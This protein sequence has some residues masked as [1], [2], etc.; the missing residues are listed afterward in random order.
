MKITVVCPRCELTDH[1]EEDQR[2]K[3]IRCPNQLCRAIIEVPVE[4]DK[5]AAAA[6][7]PAPVKPPAPAVSGMVSDMLPLLPAQFAEPTPPAP[8]PPL[9]KQ[10]PRPPKPAAKEAPA[11]K[12]VEPPAPVPAPPV[13]VTPAPRRPAPPIDFPDDFP[14]DD[15]ADGVPAPGEGPREMGPGTWEAPPVRG[16][17]AE[18]APSIAT[19]EPPPIVAPPPA[20]G[21]ATR[22]RTLLVIAAMAVVCAG[23][24]GFGLWRLENTRA[25]SEADRF[26]RALELYDQRE[27]EKT[28]EMLQK[29]ARDFPTSRDF[30]KYHFLAELSSVRADADNARELAEL[31]PAL[32]HVLQFLGYNQ[33]QTLL[34][35]RHADVWKT[36]HELSKRLTAEADKGHDSDA[37]R[38]AQQAWT[39]AKK[40]QPPAGINV[41][42]EERLFTE[43]F[44]GVTKGI[45][46]HTQR[47]GVIAAIKD[48]IAQATAVGVQQSRALA[49]AAGLKDDP[50]VTGLLADLVRAHRAAVK[51]EPATRSAVSEPIE[52]DDLP[53]LLVTPALVKATAGASPGRVVLAL[54]RGVLYALDPACGD[55]RWAR[56][57][58]IDTSVLPLHV[59]ADPITPELLLVVSSDS[60][61]IT[62]VVAATGAVAW[63]HS[64]AAPCKGQPVLVGRTLLVPTVTGRVDELEISGGRLLGHYELGQRLSVG[65]ARQPGSSLV[66]FPGDEFCVYALDVAK[67]TGAAVLYS[68]H[69]AGSLRGVPILLPAPETPAKDAEPG[70]GPPGW[71]LLCQAKGTAAVEVRPFELPIRDPDQAPLTLKTPVNVPGLSWFAPWH[72]AE[73]LALATDKGLLSLWG[74]RQK[75]N[76]DDP[77][78]FAL[79]HDFAVGSGP[80]RA[81]VVHAD[82]DDYW[83]LVGGRLHRLTAVFAPQSGPDLVRAWQK[84]PML[85]SPLHAAQ[86]YREPTGRTNL[87]V[88]T[89]GLNYPTCL[90]TAV[91]AVS[92]QLD[93]QRQ[94]GSVAL[95]P[96][97]VVG[98]R[99]LLRDANG[100]FLVDPAQFAATDDK[101]WQSV[102]DFLVRESL[103]LDE[104]VSTAVR[105]ERAGAAHLVAPG[106]RHQAPCASHTASR[107]RQDRG[108]RFTRAA[109]RHARGRRWL[110]LIAA[111]Q[112]RGM[113]AR[114]RR[115]NCRGAQLAR[116]RRRR[117]SAGPHRA[118]RGGRVSPD[119]RQPWPD[120][121]LL[122]RQGLS[123]A[124]RGRGAQPS[125][126]RGA[127]RAARARRRSAAR[128]RR[129]CVRRADAP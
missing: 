85:G 57:V 49:A 17:E 113:A 66:Y 36:L 83:A 46:L 106:C 1:Q 81:Q 126:R 73:K 43:K 82:A 10:P 7:P 26:T 97:V 30:R 59:P 71:L 124:G 35:D 24:V 90:C 99:V 58:G 38:L 52:E 70:Q 91:D 62:A 61:S 100:V 104:R 87:V 115:H 72:D 22:R 102:N 56:R 114:L 20:P 8:P 121:R 29:L 103:A 64:L 89:L 55:F 69:P 31:Q 16:V 129:R 96:P 12:P 111:G 9:A 75:G 127:G 48:R 67:K 60:K 54:A 118:D 44:A 37:L 68:N 122:A 19:L 11:K 117:A 34:K 123:R 116:C 107:R 21:H 76:R 86:P 50:E 98:G 108:S 77:L 42:E 51:Y 4:A 53:G 40:L 119:R 32:E 78:L 79:L 110:R 47:E 27:F 109:C 120:A 14:G 33:Q 128:L 95:Y 63:R 13:R 125:H 74:I 3:R 93:W 18:M 25:G 94:L 15:V 101:R 2:G 80:G 105:H 23:V 45:A 41:P 28:N 5:P 92:G 88:T 39:E 6:P 112:R 84:P 65:G